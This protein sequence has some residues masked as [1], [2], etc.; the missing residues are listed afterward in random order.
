LPTQF[1]PVGYTIESHVNDGLIQAVIHSPERNPPDRIVLRLRHPT[2]KPILSVTVNGADHPGYDAQAG[3]V[4]LASWSGT[5]LNVDV[6]Y[7]EAG[8][9]PAWSVYD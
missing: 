2:G 3:T 8:A 9:S 7:E 5:A 1:G 4:T 6:F